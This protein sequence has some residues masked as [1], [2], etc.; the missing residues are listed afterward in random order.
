[1]A[2]LTRCR[3]DP[4]TG[5]PN[6]LHV[7]YYSER[8][9]TAGFIRT[10]CTPISK[11]GLSF[12]GAAGIYT[13]EQVG[14]WKKVCEAVH[15]VN[16]I[17]FLQ[18]WHCWR[19]VVSELIDYE[20]PLSSSPVRNRHQVKSL[21]GYS[22]ADEPVEMTEEDIKEVINQFIVCAKNALKAGFDRIELHGANGYLIDQFL[23]NGVN[24]RTDKYGGSIENRCRFP[25]E[26]MDG[27]I[28]VFGNDR[29]VIKLSPVGRYNDMYDSEPVELYSYFL[30]EL[31]KRKIA[32]VELVG[33]PDFG[34][35][36]FYG[37]PGE[38]QIPDVF[39][40]LR[41]YFKGVLIANMNLTYETGSKIVQ[42]GD[43]DIISYGRLFISNPDLVERFRNNWPLAVADY[44]TFYTTGPEGYIDYPKYIS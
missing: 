12:P 44:K 4:K 42:N 31:D 20:K 1:L 37:I 14:G 16:G 25:L 30:Q 6:E 13:E 35:M 38:E 9:E 24:K 21:S 36:N 18:I 19:A 22:V 5:I 34:K 3:A 40:T 32:Y 33:A 41:P 7:Q 28:S 23:R 17:V 8:A 43:A 29:V 26:V 27:L 2:P 11:R 39:N 15:K 10:E